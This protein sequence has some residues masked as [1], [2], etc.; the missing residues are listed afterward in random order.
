[1]QVAV[2]STYGGGDYAHLAD[3]EHWRHDIEDCGDSLF[4][5][6]MIEL[7]DAEDCDSREL[8]EKRI[9]MAIDD[10]QG[11]LAEVCAM[12]DEDA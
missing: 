11:A 2:A 1:M 9:C 12:E 5:F 3:N 6:L 10:L 4:R 8:A 7:S